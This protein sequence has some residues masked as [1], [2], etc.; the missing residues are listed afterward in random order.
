MELVTNITMGQTNY[1]FTNLSPGTDYNVSV[2]SLYHETKSE[3]AAIPAKTSRYP[4]Y[5]I[6][7]MK[8]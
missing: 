1:T 6:V 3:A 2:S 5:L 7:N 8:N 4:E